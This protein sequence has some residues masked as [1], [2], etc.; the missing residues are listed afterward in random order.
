MQLVRLR[1]ADLLHEDTPIADAG[2]SEGSEG[3]NPHGWSSTRSPRPPRRSPGLR[4]HVGRIGPG[5]PANRAAEP[6]DA[7]ARPRSG[8][9]QRVLDVALG[10][11]HHGAGRNQLVESHLDRGYPGLGGEQRL[12][13]A[14][15]CGRLRRAIDTELA[16]VL[17]D[18]LD[19]GVGHGLLGRRGLRRAPVTTR[20]HRGRNANT[21]P[22][23]A[24]TPFAPPVWMLPP[25]WQ[26]R[27]SAATP[28]FAAGEGAGAFGDWLLRSDRLLP[29]LLRCGFFAATFFR[30]RLLGG[31][32]LRR[33][34]LRGWLALTMRLP[35]HHEPHRL[36]MLQHG[37]AL[38]VGDDNH[39]R[40]GIPRRDG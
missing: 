14:P 36:R 10:V 28:F 12:Q 16:K 29:Q 9:E 30:R 20:R 21:L 3:T 13:Q 35:A 1:E 38:V 17:G 33:G 31:H 37:L 39:L 26:A 27:P 22:G 34:L 40:V 2:A 7:P 24:A 32:L 6:Y 8:I 18:P 4:T 25:S 5:T 11:D 23:P 15:Q 19:V